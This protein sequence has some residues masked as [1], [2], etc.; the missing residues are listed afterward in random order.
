MCQTAVRLM[1]SRS[2]RLA[3]HG[4]IAGL[5]QHGQ[6]MA[7]RVMVGGSATSRVAALPGS[8]SRRYPRREPT[9]VSAPR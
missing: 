7:S 3:G 5:A 9:R 2:A 6:M 4:V 1:P 8:K